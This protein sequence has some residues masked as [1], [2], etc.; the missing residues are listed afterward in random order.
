MTA[1]RTRIAPIGFIGLGDQGAPMAQAIGDR[2]RARGPPN[3]SPD[4][5][6][7]HDPIRTSLT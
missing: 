3:W 4:R 1:T 2:P 6:G 5:L 7:R